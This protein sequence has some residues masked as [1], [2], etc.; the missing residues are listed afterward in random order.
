MKSVVDYYT[1]EPLL[2]G[3]NWYP[4]FPYS[5][6]TMWTKVGIYVRPNGETRSQ[7]HLNYTPTLKML[8]LCQKPAV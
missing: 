5:R 6:N 4:R 3:S 7:G 2:Q 1:K 8:A